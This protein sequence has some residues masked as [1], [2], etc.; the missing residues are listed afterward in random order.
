MTQRRPTVARAQRRELLLAIAICLRG[1]FDRYAREPLPERLQTLL[2]RLQKEPAPRPERAAK[3]LSLPLR[4]IADN[5][6]DK[7]APGA[8]KAR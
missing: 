7:R 8:A 2:D 3:S 5:R 4:R 6:D 1:M